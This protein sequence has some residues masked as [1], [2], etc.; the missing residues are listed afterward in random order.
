VSVWSKDKLIVPNDS[1][2]NV[3][4]KN[5]EVAYQDPAAKRGLL[6]FFT[7]LRPGLVSKAVGEFGIEMPPEPGW[8][9]NMGRSRS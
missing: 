5:P 6:K 9:Q 1:R 4:Q 7:F 2:H 8:L 3:N